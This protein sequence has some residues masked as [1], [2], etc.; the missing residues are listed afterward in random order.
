MRFLLV[1]PERAERLRDELQQTPQNVGGVVERLVDAFLAHLPGALTGLIL[2]VVFWLAAKI[3]VRITSGVMQR[4]HVDE[5]AREL[6]L[7]LVRIAILAIGFLTAIDQMG[8]E[9][10]SLLAGLGI[11][12]LAVG[13]A[14]QETI[15]NVIAGFSILWDRPFRLGDVVTAAGAQGEVTHIGLRSTRLRTIEY[16]EVILPNKEIVRLP[17]V[18]HTRYPEVRLAAVATI[19]HGNSVE[20]ARAAILDAVRRELP[21]VESHPPQVVVSALADLGPTLET[22]VWIPRGEMSKYTVFRLLEIVESALAA[23]GIELARPPQAAYTPP[24]V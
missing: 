11:A 22:R 5:E 8:F 6:L 14:A 4:A 1:T 23:A 15:A 10:R 21:A 2:L 16:R 19:A 7:P 24:A 17:I 20:K 13:L 3:A 12:G 18:N 9:V